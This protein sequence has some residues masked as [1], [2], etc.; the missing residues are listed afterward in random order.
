MKLIIKIAIQFLLPTL[1]IFAIPLQR[2]PGVIIY[3]TNESKLNEF[4]LVSASLSDDATEVI[5][6]FA[7]GKHND[8]EEIVFQN[9]TKHQSANGTAFTFTLYVNFP[10]CPSNNYF[11]RD[12]TVTYVEVLVR[13]T[14][15]V[16]NVE[17]LDGGYLQS[18]I[19]FAIEMNQTNLADCT[20][21]VH[22]LRRMKKQNI[23][24]E[25]ISISK[26]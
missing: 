2:Q 9:Q 3:E 18:N 8:D 12:F 20:F 17:V 19:H 13:Q 23:D 21:R 24:N 6:I 14:S 15:T 1:C 4:Q 5:K 25:L 7:L 26:I 11:C 10:N 22:A 16:A